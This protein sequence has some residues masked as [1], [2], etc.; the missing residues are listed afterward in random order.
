MPCNAVT[1]PGK[2]RRVRVKFDIDEHK[3]D[4]KV[5]GKKIIDDAKF[6]PE[7]VTIPHCVCVG[8][9]AGANAD[10]YAHICIND[11]TLEDVDDD[12]TTHTEHIEISRDGQEEEDD[13]CGDDIEE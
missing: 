2:W 11:L 12:E 7:Q 4:V 3:C 1:A 13:L 5:D 6:D 8:V 10:R 9:C